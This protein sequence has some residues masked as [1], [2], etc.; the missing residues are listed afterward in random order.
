[1]TPFLVETL[2]PLYGFY[3][4]FIRPD[5][6]AN[7]KTTMSLLKMDVSNCANQLSTSK[8][9]VGFSLNY[10]LKQLKSK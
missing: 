9:D 4:K 1:M 2:E 3:A 5:F 6:L 10:D 7:V 8:I